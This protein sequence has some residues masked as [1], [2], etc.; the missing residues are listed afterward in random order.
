MYINVHVGTLGNICPLSEG[1]KVS[2]GQVGQ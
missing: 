1:L 2:L